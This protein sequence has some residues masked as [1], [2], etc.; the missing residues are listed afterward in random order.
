MT[1]LIRPLT[2]IATVS[3]ISVAT[4]MFCSITRI[5][6]RPP[7]QPHQHV[8]DLRDD[9]RREAFGRLVHDQEPWIEQQRPR[10]RQHLLLATGELR[11]A[12]VLAFGKPRKGVVDA[13]RRPI[14]ARSRLRQP[15]M[16]VDTSAIATAGGPAAHSRCRA[17]RSRR[18]SGRSVPRQTRI[19]PLDAGTRPM[20]ALHSEVLPMPLRPTRL[21]T[22]SC[23]VRSTPCSACERP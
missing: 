23:R 13:L 10:N 8:L 16:L 21:S 3:E 20:I 11:A 22:P 9:D 1:R 5:A 12:V 2:M 17:A 4:P 18:R 19:D 14:A 7:R 6:T 15:Q